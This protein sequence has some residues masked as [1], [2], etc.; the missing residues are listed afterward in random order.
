MKII[1]LRHSGVFLMMLMAGLSCFAMNQKADSPVGSETSQGVSN[2]SVTEN[3]YILG[4]VAIEMGTFTHN[5][6]KGEDYSVA[7]G[8][9]DLDVGEGNGQVYAAIYDGHGGKRVA[10]KA[11]EGEKDD[12]GASS[13]INRLYA[14]SAEVEGGEAFLEAMKKSFIEFDESVGNVKEQG[15]TATVVFIFGGQLYLAHVG[16]SRCVIKKT[17]GSIAATRDHTP[18]DIE[19]R[20]R[21]ESVGGK[22]FE[23]PEGSGNYRLQAGL[24]HVANS[25][26]LGDYLKNG[27]KPAGLIAQPDV[28]K[29][30][31]SD[32]TYLVMA[33]D[34]LWDNVKNEEAM[35]AVEKM[36]AQ[37]YTADKVAEGLIA[38]SILKDKAAGKSVAHDD[39]TVTVM[40]FMKQ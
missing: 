29:F 25:R 24:N 5:E 18:T 14:N 40:R 21:I 3:K 37:G 6:K 2:D 7:A 36:F 13:V 9:S 16:D 11:A 28:A 12:E 30:D 34:G 32:C 31:V 20:G 27:M 33:S 23:W 10:Q 17:D 4:N 39:M 19:E 38:L 15:T 22:S 26:A 35:I 8:M 1:S